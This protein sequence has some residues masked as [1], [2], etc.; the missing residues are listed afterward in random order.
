MK[1]K[2]L[3]AKFIDKY[4]YNPKWRCV[5]CEKEIF[6]DNK[7]VCDECDKEL[8]YNIGA[9]CD[10]CGRKVISFENYCST[11]K[12]ILVSLDK[13]RSV[14]NY[15]KPISTLIQRAKYNGAKYLLEFFAK[16]LANLYLQ[17][18]FNADCLTFV[19][20]TE[21]AEKARGYNQSKVLC[22]L[23]SKKTGVPVLDCVKKVTDTK[24]QAT[25]SRKE[26][27]KNLEHAFRIFNKKQVK[28]KNIVIVDDV[29]TTGSTAEVIADRLKKAGAKRV[30]LISVASTPPSDKY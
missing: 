29:T 19:P 25:L 2:E 23:V 1:L 20:M 4:F 27:L 13:C 21:K 12:G 9:I 15:E 26:R 8:P 3:F 28:D 16:D 17:Q 30:F 10:H 7:Y 18:Y 14:Y 22:E 5:V 6:D 24:R 11:C